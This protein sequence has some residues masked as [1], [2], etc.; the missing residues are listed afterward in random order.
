ML[1]WARIY[2]DIPQTSGVPK[3]RGRVR[4]VLFFGMEKYR[5]HIAV[6]TAPTLLH[7]SVFLFFIGLVVFFFTIFK[8]VAVV[9]SI[10]VGLFGLAYF[11]LT[12]LP[13]L[14]HS[15]PY[16][17]PMSGVWWYLQNT[18][19]S[20]AAHG[21]HLFVE[22]FPNRSGPDLDARPGR[23]SNWSKRNKQHLEGGL[24]GDIFQYA[25]TAP[26][27]VDLRALTWMLQLP[28]MGEKSELQAFVDSVPPQILVQLSSL[29]SESGMTTIRDHLFNLFQGCLTNEDK[30]DETERSQ[31]LQICLDAFYHIVKPS[32]LPDS[33][34]VLQYVWSNFKDLDPVRKLWDDSNPAIRIFSL[35][36]CAHLSRNIL[37]KSNPDYSERRW[38]RV[39]VG[40]KPEDAIFDPQLPNHLSTWDHFI[41]E[42]FVFGVF[43]SLKDGLFVMPEHAACF[44]GTLAVLMNAGNSGALSKEIFS[45]EIFSFIEWTKESDYE[46]H[47]EVAAKLDQLFSKVL[48]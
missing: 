30:L 45:E 42:S 20:A 16:R 27:N 14:D 44:E 31:R 21:Y 39:F 4:S 48:Y 2:V 17:T 7:L 32:S 19:F 28:I 15:C 9:I 12:I 33:E 11:A 46:H 41:L 36:I 3:E 13:C 8:T 26:A 29:E 37:R 18:I 35:S 43:P 1:Q 25:R 23:L 6:E 22:R 10:A 47:D 40:K 24:R 34:I 5:M 38:L